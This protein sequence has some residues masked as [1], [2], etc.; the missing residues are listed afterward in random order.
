M[1]GDE[2]ENA[3][4]G[5]RRERIDQQYGCRYDPNHPEHHAH[6][7]KTSAKGRSPDH[8]HPEGYETYRHEEKPYAEQRIEYALGRLPQENECRLILG[9][10]PWNM[11]EVGD[12]G[13]SDMRESSG[14]QYAKT[15]YAKHA[16]EESGSEARPP[17]STIQG[18]E[19]GYPQDEDHQV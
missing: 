12:R 15:H 5:A 8:G 18:E 6:S 4:E 16:P 17:K 9:G 1:E 14:S 3:N 10:R 7:A 19:V 13:G 2:R 11:I